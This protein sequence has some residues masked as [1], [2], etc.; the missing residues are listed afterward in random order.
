MSDVIILHKRP[1]AGATKDR[2]VKQ[3]ENNAL[4][5][6]RSISQ[7]PSPQNASGSKNDNTNSTISSFWKTMEEQEV[8]DDSK[9]DGVFNPLS[10]LNETS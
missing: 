10:F 3:A 8:F 6:E 5:V 2:A 9:A 4:R 7:I 1:E